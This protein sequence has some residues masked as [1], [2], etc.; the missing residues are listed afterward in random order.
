MGMEMIL[1]TVLGKATLSETLMLLVMAMVIQIA[2]AILTIL[3][4][5]T[6]KIGVSNTPIVEENLAMAMA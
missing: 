5:V 4:T 1:A 6:A 2:L 3:V